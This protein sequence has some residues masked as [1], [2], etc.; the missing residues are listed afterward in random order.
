MSATQRSLAEIVGPW[1]DPAH[2]SGLIV[3][4]REAWDKPV[5]TLTNHE[6]A[7]CLRQKIAIDHLLPIAKKRAADGIDDGTEVD[8]AELVEAVK[9]T[10][11]DIGAARH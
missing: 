9:V 8:D 10:E 4:I 1:R 3:R 2:E 7:T 5:E 6:L 11:M